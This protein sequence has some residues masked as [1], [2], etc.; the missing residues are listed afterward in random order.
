M[1]ELTP[2][3]TDN[4]GQFVIGNKG[5]PK[6][7][8]NKNARDLKDFITCFLNDKSFEIPLIWDSLDDKDKA[9]L[10]I[11][12]SKMVLPKVTNEQIED[13][14]EPRVFNIPELPNIGNR[15]I[16]ILFKDFSEDDK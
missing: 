3:K 6:G 11:H 8:T 4:N 14:P 16:Q 7:A 2:K 12:L 10:F 9:T 5:K 1:K 13:K 15:E